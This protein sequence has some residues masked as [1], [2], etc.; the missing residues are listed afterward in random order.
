MFYFKSARKAYIWG[1]RNVFTSALTRVLGSTG[2][3]LVDLALQFVAF[4]LLVTIAYLLIV[5]PLH[6]LIARPSQ[7]REE[8]EQ[9]NVSP[10]STR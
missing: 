5:R 4:A 1:R 3:G 6:K 7:K 9:R 10:G 8:R 2:N